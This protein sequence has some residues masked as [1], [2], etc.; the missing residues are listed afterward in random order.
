MSPDDAPA[1]KDPKPIPGAPPRVIGLLT[2]TL[3]VVGSMVGTGVFTTTGFLVRDLASAPAVLVCWLV[4][5]VA[6]ASGA[7]AYAELTAALPRNGGEYE[8]LT[9]IYHPAVGF[10]AAFVSLVVG[11]SAP[12]AASALAFGAYAERFAP[13]AD[14]QIVALGLVLI[15]TILHAARVSTGAAFHSAMTGLLVLLLLGFIGL[16]LGR[17]D[18]GVLGTSTQPL[19]QAVLTPAFASGLVYVSFAYS[20]W[21]A[22]AYVAGEVR[23]PARNLPRALVMGTALVGLLYLGLNAVF[24]ASAPEVELSG[25]VE[26][27]HVSAIA[28]FGEDAGRFVSLLVMLALLTTASALVVTG[29]RV[30]ERVGEDYPVLARLT[31]RRREGGPVLAIALQSLLAVAMILTSSFDRLLMYMGITLSISSGLAI[32]GVFVLRWREP[33]LDRPYRAPSGAVALALAL[34]LWMVAFAMFEHPRETLWGLGT[35]G[36]GVGI[37][38]RVRGRVPPSAQYPGTG[39]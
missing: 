10:S 34:T 2:A 20:G 6:A 25:V 21:N 28:L 39:R 14:S 19:R 1:A 18:L 15:L 16:G 36:I 13:G 38:R 8:L 35:L 3:L 27:G 4:G 37:Y 23:H 9:R 30:Y 7:L 29:P 24:L 17:V 12:L 5:G 31:A 33:G 11:F 26:V 22:A 32:L